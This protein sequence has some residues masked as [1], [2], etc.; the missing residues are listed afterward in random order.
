MDNVTKNKIKSLLLKGFNKEEIINL[1]NLNKEED[2]TEIIEEIEKGGIISASSY[3]YSELQKDLSKLVISE[4]NKPDRDSTVILNAIKLQAE[5]QEKK[6]LLEKTVNIETKINKEYI[7]RRD[8]EIENL[9]K[10]GMPLEDIA[11]KFNISVL[12]IK[13]ALDRC[14]LDLPDE[15]KSL[16][17]SIITETMG[18]AKDIRIDILNNAYKNKLTRKQVREIVNKIKNETR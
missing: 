7:Y 14:A 10:E 13:Q 18:L 6:I 8:Q 12:S 9:A 1:L 17:P 11:K 4:L 2:I 3:L 5:L 15:L 16:S